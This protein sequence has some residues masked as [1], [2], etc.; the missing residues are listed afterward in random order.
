MLCGG[1]RNL[2]LDHKISKPKEISTYQSHQMI[3]GLLKDAQGLYRDYGSYLLVRTEEAITGAGN[4]LRRAPQDEVMGFELRACVSKKRKGKHIYFPTRDWRARHDWLHRQGIRN[5]FKVLTV[6][7]HAEMQEIDD[8]R[9]R[10]FM[11]D[12][13]DFVGVLKVEDPIHFEGA[14]TKGVGS[15]A[16]TYGFGMLII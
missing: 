16:T 15:T 10:K 2:F 8:S 6:N 9:G 13:T 7:C 11:V 12:Q 4:P 3:K 1:D 14:L 5:G